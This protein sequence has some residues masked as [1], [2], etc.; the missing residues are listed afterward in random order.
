MATDL[1][2][3]EQRKW[4][5]FTELHPVY[6]VGL[7]ECDSCIVSVRRGNQVVT[8]CKACDNATKIANEIAFGSHDYRQV[9]LYAR[10]NSKVA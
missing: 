6:G 5:G 1:L 2:M 10:Q 7:Y 8:V 9:W 3:K 4:K